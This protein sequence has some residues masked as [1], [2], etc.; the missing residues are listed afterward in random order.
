MAGFR[1]SVVEG[2]LDLY[3]TAHAREATIF[4]KCEAVGLQG[5]HV[6]PGPIQL[7]GRDIFSDWVVDAGVVLVDF[8]IV[9]NDPRLEKPVCVGVRVEY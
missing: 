1:P 8:E 4:G 6:V 9:E 2:G 3:F 5:H 7:G